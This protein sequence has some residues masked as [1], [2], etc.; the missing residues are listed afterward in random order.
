L[1]PTPIIDIDVYTAL[2]QFDRRFQ[3]DAQFVRVGET[4]RFRITNP[5]VL[6]PQA[7]IRWVV[8]NVGEHA[9]REND[10]GHSATDTGALE[11]EE[12]AKYLGRHF[13]DCE[14]YQA[15]RIRSITRVPV[16]I[17]AQPMPVRH[18]P[19]PA[20]RRLGRR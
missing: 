8:R 9:Y 13:M 11:H 2:G 7:H 6:P 5:A 15:G 19:L 20:Y 1:V 18:P 12:H 3:G 14:V 16:H 17:A 4:L 10:L